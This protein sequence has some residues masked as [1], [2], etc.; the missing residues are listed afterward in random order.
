MNKLRYLENYPD[1]LVP[2]EAMQVLSVGR[3]TIYKLLKDNIIKSL[4]IGKLYRIPKKCLQ[5][6]ID[7]CY[8][9]NS[10]SDWSDN[11]RKERVC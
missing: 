10:I 8:N 9:S 5:D 1:V 7:S 3:N 6:Y 4:R 2:E 11:T